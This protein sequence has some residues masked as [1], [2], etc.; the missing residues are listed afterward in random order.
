MG[1]YILPVLLSMNVKDL[2]HKARTG[3]RRMDS[4]RSMKSDPCGSNQKVYS[5]QMMG[6]E[7]ALN[8]LLASEYRRRSL[9]SSRRTMR[10]RT[11]WGNS[12]VNGTISRWSIGE[13]VN[14]SAAL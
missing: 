4:Q 9:R 6:L 12:L 7:S 10:S 13:M 11:V 5:S 2:M 3:F 8:C 1:L 14:T